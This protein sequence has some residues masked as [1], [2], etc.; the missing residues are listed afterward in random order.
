MSDPEEVIEPEIVAEEET[1]LAVFEEEQPEA[2]RRMREA[3]EHVETRMKLQWEQEK[4]ERTKWKKQ[5]IRMNARM[6]L[7]AMIAGSILGE[8]AMG[9]RPR[10]DQVADMAVEFADAVMLHILKTE[11]GSRCPICKRLMDPKEEDSAEDS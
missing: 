5:D 3:V 10:A 9:S 8:G 7:T 1:G 11:K 4:Q 6:R 2:V